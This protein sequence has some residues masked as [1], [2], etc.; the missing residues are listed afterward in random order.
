MN[1]TNQIQETL[2]AIQGFDTSK[3]KPRK[4]PGRPRALS[5]E[6]EEAIHKLME[7]GYSAESIAETF[8]V[9]VWTV[10]EIQ[11]RAKTAK[12]NQ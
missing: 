3:L 2:S 11:R 6:A 4:Y 12:S 10:Y 5:P 1:I 9:S 7:S 8:G